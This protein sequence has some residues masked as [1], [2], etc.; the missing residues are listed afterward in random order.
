MTPNETRQPRP[1]PMLDDVRAIRHAISEECGNDLGLL[2]E[3]LKI[4]EQK[5]AGRVIEAGSNLIEPVV[6]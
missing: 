1:D 6:R 5:H 3:R 2:Y 4:V